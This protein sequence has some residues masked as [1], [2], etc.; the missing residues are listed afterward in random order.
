MAILVQG[1]ARWSTIK[2]MLGWLIYTMQSTITL[3]PHRL[4]RL[5]T[6]LGSIALINT[7]CL[8]RNGKECWENSEP[9]LTLDDF[10]W[11]ADSLHNYQTR[12]RELVAQPP[13]LYGLTDASGQGMGGIILPPIM[14]QPLSDLPP[15]VWRLRFPTTVQ[16]ERSSNGSMSHV[17]TSPK[18]SARYCNTPSRTK[19]AIAPK[20]SQLQSIQGPPLSHS[21]ISKLKYYH[22]NRGG[23]PT[24]DDHHSRGGQSY[25][26]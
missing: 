1:D 23:Q 18:Y 6:I 11:L 16:R 19:T 2:Q 25:T 24:I 12:L 20:S 4:E 13:C 5:H 10:K 22:R 8:F 9:W 14:E 7:E 26:T 3:P 21:S 15:L 17:P